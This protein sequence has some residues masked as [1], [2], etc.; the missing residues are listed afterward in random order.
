MTQ[1][2][3]KILADLSKSAREAEKDKA[4]IDYKKAHAEYF[5][6]MADVAGRKAEGSAAGDKPFKMDEDDKIRVKD[7]SAS[8][9]DAEKMVNDAMKVLAPGE[10]PTQS[11]AVR[12]AQGILKQAKKTQLITHIQTGI[13]TP[14]SL[15]AKIMGSAGSKEDVFKSLKELADN[16]GTDYADQVALSLQGQDKWKVLSAPTEAKSAPNSKTPTKASVTMQNTA[17]AAPKEGDTRTVTGG[18]GQGTK[19][20]VLKRTGRGGVTLTWVDQ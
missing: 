4:D 10:D 19:T 2:Q 11:P 3:T 18:R 7:A 20:Q 5:T 16:V 8:V 13:E 14:E 15:V 12:H 6:K 1:H 9:R 17:K